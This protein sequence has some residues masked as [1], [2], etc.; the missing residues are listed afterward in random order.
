MSLPTSAY[1]LFAWPETAHVSV[2]LRQESEREGSSGISLLI[3]FLDLD[4]GLKEE[5]GKPRRVVWNML[6]FSYQLKG[7]YHK[8]SRHTSCM[9]PSSSRLVQKPCHIHSLGSPLSLKKAPLSC[10]RGKEVNDRHEGVDWSQLDFHLTFGMFAFITFSCAPV[11]QLC[12]Y[13]PYQLQW[14]S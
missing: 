2:Y 11:L 8:V 14:C 4:K 6:H 3:S 1:H 13:P 7:S 10:K 9:E 12:L 5:E